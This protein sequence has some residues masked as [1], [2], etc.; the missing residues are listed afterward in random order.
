MDNLEY[1]GKCAFAMSTGK[2]NVLGGKHTATIN[3]KTYAF[4]NP[5]AKFLFK[6]LPGRVEKADAVWAEANPQTN[7]GQTTL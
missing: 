4:S 1:G 3:G 6:L 2:T 7:P 5:V